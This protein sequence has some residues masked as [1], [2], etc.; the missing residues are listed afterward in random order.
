MA[1]EETEKGTLFHKPESQV[2]HQLQTTIQH[3]SHGAVFGRK[4][5][6]EKMATLYGMLSTFDPLRKK[7]VTLD[8]QSE[9]LCDKCSQIRY[10][11]ENLST[12]HHAVHLAAATTPASPFSRVLEHQDQQESDSGSFSQQRYSMLCQDPLFSG[13]Q[14]SAQILHPEQRVLSHW[15]LFS[16]PMI[17]MCS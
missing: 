17:L 9:Y 14:G 3:C 10:G 13:F 11:S 1:A 7:I 5:Y 4:S 15:P 6:S 16:M 8:A 12:R 2:V